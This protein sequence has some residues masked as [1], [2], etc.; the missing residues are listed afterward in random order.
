MYNLF[1]LIIELNLLFDCNSMLFDS[2]WSFFKWPDDP[3]LAGLQATYCH[4]MSCS[5]LFSLCHLDPWVCQLVLMVV[6]NRLFWEVSKWQCCSHLVRSGRSSSNL[7]FSH[8]AGRLVHSGRSSSDLVS[9]HVAGCLVHSGRSLSDLVSSHVAGRLVRSGRSSGAW[10]RSCPTYTC[11]WS[12]PGRNSWR[13]S[14]ATLTNNTKK[15]KAVSWST[16]CLSMTVVTVSAVINAKQLLLSF[17]TVV[18]TVSLH[19]SSFCSIHP[20][21]SK[22]YLAFSLNLS[23][24]IL[25]EVSTLFRYDHCLPFT[26]NNDF[27]DGFRWRTM[28]QLLW[29]RYSQYSRQS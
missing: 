5:K 23:S 3:A 18:D 21:V 29:K 20:P 9:S 2:I 27:V 14:T 15:H 1:I 17:C 25:A 26:S 10:R 8:V 11:S 6:S 19:L 13:T 4:L 22:L 7:L 24:F 16:F 28:N 12:T